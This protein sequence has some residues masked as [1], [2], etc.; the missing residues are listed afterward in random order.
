M[1]QPEPGD[2]NTSFSIDLAVLADEFQREGALAGEQEVGGAVLV[3]VGVAA[4][5]ERLGPAGHQARH[6]LADDGLAEDHAAQDVAD[7]AVGRL[8]HLLELELFDARL[9]G[10]DGRA[11]DGDA[12]LLGGVGR[13]D[14]DLVVGLV[15]VLH[16]EVVVLEVHVDVGV[17]QLVL[18]QLPDDARHLIAVHLDDG[19]GNLDLL[20]V[21]NPLCCAPRPATP[22]ASARTAAKLDKRRKSPSLDTCS[23]IEHAYDG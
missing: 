1:T 21:A 13:I 23:V 4:D 17:D 10:R 20:H 22:I 9:I 7:G 16:A 11:L 3:A 15:A 14:R 18:D 6:V 5:H 19:A 2:L 12:V 8:P